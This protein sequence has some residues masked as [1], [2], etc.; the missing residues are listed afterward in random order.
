MG[1]LERLWRSQ[2]LSNRLKA[3]LIQTLV[4][5]IVT[6]G[7][8]SWTLN[9]DLTRNIEAFEMQCYRKVLRI[10]HVDHVTSTEVLGRMGQERMLLKRV[11]SR[12]LKYFGHVA[13]VQNLEHD[14]M[15]GPVPGKRRQGG[16]RKQWFDDVTQWIGKDLPTCYRLAEGRNLFR[17]LIRRVA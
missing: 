4:W 8:E 5:P 11:K 3:R 1:S 7:S 16:H 15:F 2:T 13:R 10:P 12:K 9:F 17:H 6:Y 14:V